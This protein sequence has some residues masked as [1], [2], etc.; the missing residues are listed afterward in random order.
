MSMGDTL[1]LDL[2][3][4]IRALRRSPGFTA[5][6][7]IAP[8]LGIGATQRRNFSLLNRILLRP[9]CR[10]AGPAHIGFAMSSPRREHR[11]L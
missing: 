9:G 6:A 2:R 3:Y 1:L 4:A 5:L 10:S 11:A 7:V 8:G